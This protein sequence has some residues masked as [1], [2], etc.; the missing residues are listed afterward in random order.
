MKKLSFLILILFS[1]PVLSQAQ[2]A[3]L[4]MEEFPKVGAVDAV[5]ITIEGSP[6]NIQHVLE[7]KFMDETGTRLKS[8]K[9]F[10][11]LESAV[12]RE[13]ASKT[14]DYYFK[15]QKSGSKDLPSGRVVLM[16]SLG[17]NSFMDGDR[18]PDEMAA[19]KKILEELPREVRMYELELAIEEQEKVIGKSVKDYDRMGTDSINLEVQ[20]IETQQAIEAN[21]IAREQ[22]RKKM[23]EEEARLREFRDLLKTTRNGVLTPPSMERTPTQ[24]PKEDE[25]DP[26]DDNG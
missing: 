22:Q 1:L 8:Y 21:K 11:K 26:Q 14:V 24:V 13:I 15:V 12:Y 10:R 4:T 18:Y 23:A 5:A 2:Q 6:K 25:E 9:G 20:L 7:E 3:S 19:A 17:N 16:L